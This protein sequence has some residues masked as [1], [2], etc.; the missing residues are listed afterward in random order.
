MKS[1]SEYWRQSSDNCGTGYGDY[2]DKT[3]N[4]YCRWLWGRGTAEK[5][6]QEEKCKCW[7]YLTRIEANCGLFVSVPRHPENVILVI[8]AR[9]PSGGADPMALGH[10]AT[11]VGCVGSQFVT[12]D[13]ISTLHFIDYA[14]L[15]RKRD[16]MVG[17]NGEAP[18]IDL[19]TLR[20]SARAAD[21]EKSQLRKTSRLHRSTEPTPPLDSGKTSSQQHH[22]GS[23]QLIPMMP[24][25]QE[26]ELDRASQDSHQG[27]PPGSAHMMGPIPPPPWST[28]VQSTTPGARGYAPEQL[29]HQSFLRTSHLGDASPS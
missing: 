12:A 23:F 4:K 5:Q 29:Q 11:L 13:W 22:Q 21:M 19:E 6:I 7:G 14:K 26:S 18:R 28:S 17:S 1:V 24:T 10:C 3:C 2:S 16:K 27:I 20:A 8:S 9:P 25:P 15:Q